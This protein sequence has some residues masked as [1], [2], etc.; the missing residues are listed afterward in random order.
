VPY[1]PPEWL[2]AWGR[3]IAEFRKEW[4]D[5]DP[6]SAWHVVSGSGGLLALAVII[7]KVLGG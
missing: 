2:E 5:G 1:G 7:E 6:K 4:H 3:W